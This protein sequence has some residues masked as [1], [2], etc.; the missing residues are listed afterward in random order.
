MQPSP[1]NQQHTT[2]R[3]TFRSNLVL[4][5]KGLAMGSADVVPGVSGGTMALILG[6]YEELIESLRNVSTPAFFNAVRRLR[7]GEAF[8]VVNGG[9]LV[10]LVAGIAT[11]VALFSSF[12]PW[13]LETQQVFVYS[14]FFGLVAASTWAVG[15]RVTA[16]SAVTVSALIVSALGAFFL[17]GL[18]PAETPEAAWFIVLSGALAICAMVLPGI[19]GSFILL[20]LGK[21][22]YVL[23]A[24]SDL[25]L[26]VIFLF[27]TGALVGLLS[28]V[29]LLSWL[30]D[31]Y[32]N[33]TIALLTGF[34]L[35]SLR[36]IYPWKSGLVSEEAPTLATNVLPPVLVNG[37]L[38]GAF[39]G[40][41]ALIV[42]GAALVLALEK[43]GE[44][45]S[46]Q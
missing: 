30:F 28:F 42:L 46:S 5:L 13:L 45:S 27:G 38:S 35:G 31:R 10:V 22:A 4:Y 18:S 8:R 41:L 7:I 33:L 11:A 39:L 32:Y 2:E 36:K 29:R 9:F 44:G 14:F 34:L 3:P 6:I 17:V 1:A 24:V 19:S 23:N 20:L 26:S 25:N 15:R 40:A 43:V 16:W 37:E 21:Y 12:L